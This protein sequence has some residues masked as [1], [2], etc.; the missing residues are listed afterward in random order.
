[1]DCGNSGTTARL[2]MGVL[3]G[4]PIE[5]TLVGDES[6]SARPMRRVTAPLSEMGAEFETDA[7]GTLPVTVRGSS[8]LKPFTYE[9]PVAS[10]QVK[11]AILLA[12]LRAKGGV[13]VSEPAPSRDHTERLLPAFGVSLTTNA[14]AN[15]VSL[16]GPQVPRPTDIAVPRDPS[17]AAFLVAA[18]LLVPGSRIVLPGVS[19]NPTRIG[20]LKVLERMGA[21]V[22]IT[23]SEVMGTEPV[24]TVTACCT[25][26][27]RPTLVQAHEV[28]SLVDEVPVLALVATQAHGVTRFEGVGELRVKESDRLAAVSNGLAALGAVVRSGDDW[29]E[30]EG[31][32]DLRGAVLD[33]LGDHR[34]AMCWALAGIAALSPVT[35]QRYEA[36]EVSYPQF[37]DALASLGA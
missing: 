7:G 15:S 1:I 14:A 25:P 9:S 12:G 24:G 6:L 26:R 2:L 31:P 33:S 5:A 21:D 3:A 34:L 27:L 19:L 16:C 11:T 28:P 13:R 23:N 30:V 17:S 22:E 10:A 20:F 18:A 29:L 4:W 32:T 35:V 36:V 37:A 8:S